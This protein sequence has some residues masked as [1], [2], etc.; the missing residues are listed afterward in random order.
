MLS[1]SNVKSFNL[2]KEHEGNLY[3]AWQARSEEFEPQTEIL[4]IELLSEFN[5][6]TLTDPK[7]TATEWMST[8]ELQCHQLK[9]M[10]HN[11]TDDHLT[12]HVLANLLKEYA[13]MTMQLYELLGEKKLRVQKLHTQL[14]LFYTTLKKANNWSS[15]DTALNLQH[16]IPKKSF[17]GKCSTCR[18]QGHNSMD[19]CN[20]S[21]AY[22]TLLGVLWQMCHAWIT[23]GMVRRTIQMISKLCGA[24]KQ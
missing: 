12:M 7:S 10:G 19:C 14:K 4:V 9:A 17:K 2:V 16:S 5:G 24:R 20:R 18:K 21:L 22:P 23:Y 3:N 13:V 1:M 8:L 11:I 6:N 15:L